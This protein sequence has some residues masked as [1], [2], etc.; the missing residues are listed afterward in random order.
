[1][2]RSIDRI[3]AAEED[4]LENEI[5]RYFAEGIEA[6]RDLQVSPSIQEMVVEVIKAR[7]GAA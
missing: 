3:A 5:D 7:Q 6:L 2:E 4:S 1:M